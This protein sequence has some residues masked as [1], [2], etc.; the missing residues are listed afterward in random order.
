[1]AQNDY[2]IF[3][4]SGVDG[5]NKLSLANYTADNDRVYGN[6]YTTKLIRSQLVN[7]VLQQTSKISSAVAQF[8]VNNGISA[9]DT[10]SVSTIAT[11]LGTVI[12]PLNSPA[13]TGTPTAPTAVSGTNNT[14]IATTAFAVGSLSTGSNGYQKLPSGLI[15]QWGTF[16]GNS[17]QNSN[18]AI[19]F[20]I[21]F[22][23]VVM[24]TNSNYKASSFNQYASNTSS[25]TTSGMN[26]GHNS[27]SLQMQ[28]IAIGY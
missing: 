13:L 5:V 17:T 4:D 27:P 1:M 11:K 25:V 15:V 19:T 7:K 21:V 10:D 3:G 18:D 12:A 24:Y 23:N 14:Q 9:L 28:W 6:G 16:T 22:P 20:P 26:V 8:L 2:Q